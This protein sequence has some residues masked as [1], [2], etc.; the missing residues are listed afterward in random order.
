M[1][2]GY[3]EVSDKKKKFMFKLTKA[4]TFALVEMPGRKQTNNNNS[5][6]SS[7]KS[8]LRE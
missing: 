2:K 4:C 3:Q 5:Y 7:N 6:R 8:P 1:E